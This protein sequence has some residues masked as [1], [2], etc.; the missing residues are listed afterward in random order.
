MVAAAASVHASR[1]SR[2]R[3]CEREHA[4]PAG[5]RGTESDPLGPPDEP[6]RLRSA[7]SP[8]RLGDGPH[9]RGRQPS[10]HYGGGRQHDECN[11]ALAAH[12]V[13]AEEAGGSNGE[14]ER[15][16]LRQQPAGEEPHPAAEDA[17]ARRRGGDVDVHALVCV[18]RDGHAATSA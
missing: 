13:G 6:A 17:R 7:A 8:E 14:D 1:R 5:D 16:G 9:D 15:E 18:R 11:E 4:R 10:A 12:R 2:A 3:N